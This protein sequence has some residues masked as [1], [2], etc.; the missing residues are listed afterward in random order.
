MTKK[1]LVVDDEENILI[2]IEFLLQRAGYEVA[3]ARDG[4]EALAQAERFSPDLVLLDVMMPKKDGYE[5]CRILRQDPRYE[6][7]KIVL[8]TAKGRDIDRAKGLAQGA[9][10]YLTKPFAT[11]ELLERVE[12]LLA[13]APG[14]A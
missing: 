5:V 1:I 2:S 13:P 6:R 7:C 14:A 11:R 8:L 9:D 3:V 4:D 12:H 10:D